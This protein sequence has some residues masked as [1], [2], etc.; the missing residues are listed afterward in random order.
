MEH[1]PHDEWATHYIIPHT[2]TRKNDAAKITITRHLPHTTQVYELT[3]PNVLVTHRRHDER[4]TIQ[5]EG[6]AA[7]TLYTWTTWVD[8]PHP[9]LH[10]TP[11]WPTPFH[12]ADRP[13]KKPKHTGVHTPTQEAEHQHDARRKARTLHDDHTIPR[14]SA[15]PARVSDATHKRT[16][17]GIITDCLN[18]AA[19][20]ADAVWISEGRSHTR[21]VARLNNIQP[22]KLQRAVGPFAVHITP[23]GINQP[24][25]EH[26]DPPCSTPCTSPLRQPLPA[27]TITGN[28]YLG[29]VPGD[30]GIQ[31][32][33]NRTREHAI[34]LHGVESP[35]LGPP[36]PKHQHEHIPGDKRMQAPDGGKKAHQLAWPTSPSSPQ[37]TYQRTSAGSATSSWRGKPTTSSPPPYTP[38]PPTNTTGTPQ[39]SQR[40]PHH[41]KAKTIPS[42]FSTSINS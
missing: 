10:D 2:T 14:I 29:T 31:I 17:T 23:Y 22:H 32:L 36:P 37:P 19:S 1:T 33:P 6:A 24:R 42:A 8:L 38:S 28:M 21:A 41:R 39:P 11:S 3:A 5:A 7:I 4:Y 30:P 9:T 34:P 13:N 18:P 35:A 16:I 20:R 25:C 15:P 27:P 12:T 40:C 26:H